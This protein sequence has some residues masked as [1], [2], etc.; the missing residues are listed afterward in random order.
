MPTAREPEEYECTFAPDRAVFRR[1]DG[2]IETR[3]EIVVSP[4][5]DAELRRVSVTNLGTS[6]RR[7]D[8][9]SYAEVVLASGDADLAHPAFSN[10]FVETRSVAGRDALIA[11][12][13]PRAGTERQYLVHLLRDAD[14]SADA[15]FE[16]P[17][18]FSVVS[19]V[20]PSAGDV[21]RTLSNTVGRC[22][23]RSS[24][25]VRGAIAPVHGTLPNGS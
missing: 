20:G 21:G 18:Q 16:P 4:E 13:R 24:A 1:V 6:P 23:T 25:C 15:Q 17:G 10:L 12:R 7:L 14:R 8:L 2:D 19:A 3:T 9:T 5:D 11:A 22:S